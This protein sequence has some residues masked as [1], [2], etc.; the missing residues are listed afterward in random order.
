MSCFTVI[1]SPVKASAFLPLTCDHLARAPASVHAGLFPPSHTATLSPGTMCD[2]TLHLTLTPPLLTLPHLGLSAPG[3]HQPNYCTSLAGREGGER[4]WDVCA[5]LFP[6]MVQCLCPFLEGQPPQ[7]ELMLHCGP[8]PWAAVI[9]PWMSK[10]RVCLPG[11]TRAPEGGPAGLL[12]S[13]RP[14]PWPRFLI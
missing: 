1:S 11:W 3:P 4:R 12:C 8:P 7:K 6:A 10:T 14:H 2:L 13:H 5:Q 9:C